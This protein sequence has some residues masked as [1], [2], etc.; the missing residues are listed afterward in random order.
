[1]DSFADVRSEDGSTLDDAVRATATVAERYLERRDR[2]GLVAFGG[3]LR[4]IRPGMGVTQRYRLI[5]TL[6]ETGVEPTY[7]WRDV[8]VLPGEDPPAEV[9][10]RRADPAR[11]SAL[12]ER[13]RGPPRSQLRPGRR[14][15]RSR[16]PL[17]SRPHSSRGPRVPP[18]APR[19]G[20]APLSAGGLGIAIARWGEAASLEVALE[21][22]RTYRRYARLARVLALAVG[23]LVCAAGLAVV[24]L[25]RA[26]DLLLEVGVRVAVVA[27]VTLLAALVLGWPP[28]VPASLLL[29]GGL[30]GAQLA[31]DDAPLDTACALVAAGLYVTAELAYWSLEERE[32]VRAEGGEGWR[33]LGLVASLGL[34]MVLAAGALLALVDALRTRGLT[35]DVLGAAAAAAVLVFVLLARRPAE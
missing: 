28:L 24:P 9:A 23:A 34:A 15:D 35:V 33:R 26:S 29:L 3:V 10:R 30:Y 4:W 27:V 1:M 12:R 6:L 5:E 11:R 32:N 8:N 21:G 16:H 31:V 18:L 7:T 20:G 25:A 22:V 2:V 13:A 19:A 17:R 14:R